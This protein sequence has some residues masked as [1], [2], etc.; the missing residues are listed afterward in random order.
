MTRLTTGLLPDK[1][2]LD[3]ADVPVQSASDTRDPENWPLTLGETLIVYHP[4][5]RILPRVVLTRKL[6]AV[7]RSP[8]GLGDPLPSGSD[9]QP[10]HFPF[11]S[12]ADFKQT[13]LFVKCDF[14]DGEIDNQLNLW[15]CHA[16]HGTGVTLKN[17][18]EMHQCLQAASTKDNLSQVSVFSYVYCIITVNVPT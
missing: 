12:L 9:P 5:T 17:A 4:H 3:R 13:E 6:M 11:R 15:K 2:G 14:T 16:A 18:Q 1:R 10:L 8:E 7:R